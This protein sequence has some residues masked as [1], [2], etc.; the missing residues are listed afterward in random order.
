MSRSGKKT[1]LW[2]RHHGTPMLRGCSL[3]RLFGEGYSPEDG[4]EFDHLGIENNEQFVQETMERLPRWNEF[5]VELNKCAGH[6]PH[7][8]KQAFCNR[9]RSIVNEYSHIALPPSTQVVLQNLLEHVKSG[10]L[11]AGG[12]GKDLL[13]DIIEELLQD[14]RD[15]E[16]KLP[17]E[18]NLIELPVPGDYHA[19]GNNCQHDLKRVIRHIKLLMFKWKDAQQ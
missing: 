8:S 5:L 3:E 19:F 6:A 4:D 14:M 18:L 10:S 11:A 15:T 7:V 1:K 12:N 16:K 2:P 13:K 9:L 17:P